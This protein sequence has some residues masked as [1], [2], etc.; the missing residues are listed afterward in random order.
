ML[1]M[2]RRCK[3]IVDV[4]LQPEETHPVEMQQFIIHPVRKKVTLK[5]L[6]KVLG[7]P[8]PLPARLTDVKATFPR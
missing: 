4:F 7:T 5:T 8:P 6:A 2:V 1:V 3:S